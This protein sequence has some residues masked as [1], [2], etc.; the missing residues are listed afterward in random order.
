MIE[1]FNFLDKYEKAVFN[2]IDS[3]TARFCM[4][5]VFDL[6]HI[7]FSTVNVHISYILDGDSVGKHVGDSFKLE[8]FLEWYVDVIK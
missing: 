3:F 7:S 4:C 8:K 1:E 2:N 5:P 6:Y